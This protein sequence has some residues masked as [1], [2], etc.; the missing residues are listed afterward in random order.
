MFKLN[1]VKARY[2]RLV[3]RGNT[4]EKSPNCI[5]ITE[6][7]II[8][9]G[10]PS[11]PAPLPSNVTVQKDIEY[12]PGGGKSRTLDLYR[13]KSSE[14]ALPLMVFIHGGGWRGGSKDG[15]PAR[16][17]A[18]HGYAVASINYRLSREA[19]FPAQIEDCRA[20]LRFLRAQ[21]GKYNLQPDRVAVWGGSAGGHL[22]A[23]LGTS[24]AVDFSGGPDAKNVVGKVDESVRVQAVVDMYGAS[25]LA[26]LMVN[27]AWRDHGVSRAAIQLLGSSADDPELMKKSK[28]A[29]PVTYVGRDTPPFLIQHGDADRIMPLEQARVMDAVLQKA[30]VETTLMVMPGAGHAG[31]AFFS[32]ENRKTLVAFLDRHLKQAGVALGQEIDKKTVEVTAS[33]W[34]SKAHGGFADFPPELTLDGKL[35]AKSSWR[36]DGKGQWIQYDLGAAKPLAE[37]RIAFV[38]GNKRSYTIDILVSK[39]GEEKD[40][41]TVAEKA[42]SSGKTAEYEPFKLNG[43]EARYVRVVGQGNTSEK[44]PTWINITEVA[45]V[46]AGAKAE[47]PARQRPR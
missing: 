4:S 12:V 20:A 26:L 30:G 14:E 47:E 40:W 38:S 27:K 35:E 21:A 16:F 11:K 23:L 32:G 29:S 34:E 18:Q 5:N 7:M 9:G 39:T 41:T 17:L 15:C 8:E 46:A 43:A 45:F 24:A 42:A 31:G 44:F 3:C 33:A 25:D 2:M 19:K 13:P 36:A 28:W 1:G 37:V 22:A 6:V 10:P